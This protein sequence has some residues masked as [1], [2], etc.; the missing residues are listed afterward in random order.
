MP[1]N[2]FSLRVLAFCVVVTN[3]L[4][5]YK[6]KNVFIFQENILSIL[7]NVQ[8]LI[9]DCKYIAF[10]LHI[11]MFFLYKIVLNVLKYKK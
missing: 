4:S 10:I 3:I 6:D 9:N 11:S 5:C 2:F 8:L 1:L 7:I